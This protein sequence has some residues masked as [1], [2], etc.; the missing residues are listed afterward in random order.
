MKKIADPDDLTGE[1]YK[2]LKKNQNKF[3]AYFSKKIRG[4]NNF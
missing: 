4:D 3:F 2:H 1:L